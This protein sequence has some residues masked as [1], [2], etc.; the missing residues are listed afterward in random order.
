MMMGALDGR[1]EI[2]EG[3]G[4]NETNFVWEHGRVTN[5]RA[6]IG[7]RLKFETIHNH[8]TCRSPE[9]YVRSGD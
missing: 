5:R 8:E 2:G 6:I 3:E 9:G 7:R 4:R 1:S